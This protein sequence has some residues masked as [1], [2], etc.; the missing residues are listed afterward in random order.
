MNQSYSP[1]INPLRKALDIELYSETW[2]DKP[3]RTSKPLV[4][5]DHPVLTFQ[6][7]SPSPFTS[8]S[9]FHDVSK[10]PCAPPLINKFPDT[11]IISSLSPLVLFNSL[12]NSNCLFF[13]RY[14]P[15]DTFKQRWFLVQINYDETSLLNMTPETT[16][17][18][19]VNFLARHLDDSHLCD[20][21]ARWWL[22][23]HEYKLIS[24]NIPVYSARV[25]FSPKQKPNLKKYVMV[26]LCNSYRP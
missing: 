6:E 4:E 20:E 1:I 26:R 5:Y 21:K 7:S 12:S 9:D 22:E 25:L 2:F 18:Y 23:W 11:D 13:I 15:E 14:T 8:V 19:H 10:T 16:D 24:N 3:P 17:D